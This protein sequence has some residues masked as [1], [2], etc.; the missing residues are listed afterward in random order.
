MGIIS[1]VR[2]AENCSRVAATFPA[3]NSSYWSGVKF[4]QDGDAAMGASAAVVAAAGG[5]VAE[6]AIRG[7]A[8]EMTTSELHV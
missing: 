7:C 3:S 8:D 5:H 1:A 2:K 4:I 6:V